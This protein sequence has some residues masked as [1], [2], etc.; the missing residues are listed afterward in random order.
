M[1]ML[2]DF[3]EILAY[4]KKSG[5]LT[6]AQ[7]YIDS[8]WK[9]FSDVRLSDFGFTGYPFTWDNGRARLAFVEEQLD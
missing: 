9:I 1:V 7:G 2:G 4:S 5:G 8:F 6:R 3:N